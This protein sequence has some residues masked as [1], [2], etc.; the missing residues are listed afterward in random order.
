M[1]AAALA[2]TAAGVA[3]AAVGGQAKVTICHATGSAT[4]PFVRITVATPAAAMA[5]VRHQDERDIIAPFSYQG[6]SYSLNWNATGEAT[7]YNGCQ[8]PSGLGG[9]EFKGKRVKIRF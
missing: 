6:Q 4:N 5:H 2:G 1:S 7:F 3:G 8:A 9:G